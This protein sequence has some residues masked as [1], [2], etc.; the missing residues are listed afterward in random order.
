MVEADPTRHAS[1]T[2]RGAAELDLGEAATGLLRSRLP[3]VAEDTVRAIIVEVPGYANALAGPM[4][5]NIQGAVQLAL[6]GFLSLASRPAAATPARRWRPRWRAP[7]PWAGARRAA[8][9]AWTRCSR[10]TGSAPGCRG[11]S[12][13]P[14]RSRPA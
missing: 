2:A 4:G 11:A 13:R 12:C 10:P 3:A 1:R 6:G 14:R 7:T 5:A 9:A 8:A